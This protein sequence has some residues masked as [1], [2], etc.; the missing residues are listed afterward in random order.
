MH[1]SSRGPEWNQFVICV[2]IILTS[3]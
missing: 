2:A 3:K 1:A